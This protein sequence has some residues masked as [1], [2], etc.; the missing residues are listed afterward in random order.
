MTILQLALVLVASIWAAFNTLI[1]GY[2]AVNGTRDRILTGRTDEGYPLSIEHRRLMYRNDWVPLKM[3]LAAVSLA[4]AGFIVMLPEFAQDPEALRLIC[5]VGAA[6]PFFAFLGFFVLG[7]SDRA[8]I[9]RTLAE[10]R[11]GSVPET[12]EPAERAG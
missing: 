9:L 2:N 5:Y 10:A 3:G 4:F 1:A 11:A 12:P 8:L 7:L 6:L